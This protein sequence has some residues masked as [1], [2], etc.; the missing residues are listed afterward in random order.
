MDSKNPKCALNSGS[1]KVQTG[2]CLLLDTSVRLDNRAGSKLEE[3]TCLRKRR[4]CQ[5]S[6][7]PSQKIRIL[8]SAGARPAAMKDT[9]LPVSAAP[10]TSETSELLSEGRS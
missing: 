1:N 8:L 3:H 5:L 4:R 10:V 6:H 7:R 2:T 9:F